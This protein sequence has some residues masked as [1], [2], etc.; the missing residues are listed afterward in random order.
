MCDIILAGDR[1]QCRCCHWNAR[2]WAL[3]S[4][5]SKLVS[6]MLKPSAAIRAVNE[7]APICILVFLS[8]FIFIIFFCR[9]HPSRLTS[10]PHQ[11]GNAEEIADEVKNERRCCLTQ[12][13][14]SGGHHRKSAH[15]L[16]TGALN[17]VSHFLRG[18]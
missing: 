11:L 4:R 13:L 1:R 7:A 3:S 5:F 9:K 18:R 14:A 16:R 10:W 8:F 2:P 12:W 17:M 15:S 6:A